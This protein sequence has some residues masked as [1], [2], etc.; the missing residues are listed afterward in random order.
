M[1]VKDLRE[2]L[3]IIR[4]DREV[5]IPAPDLGDSVTH[6]TVSRIRVARFNREGGECLDGER[7]DSMA[8]VLEA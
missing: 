8:V 6:R 3:R 2:K 4:P 1:T 7:A 5:L